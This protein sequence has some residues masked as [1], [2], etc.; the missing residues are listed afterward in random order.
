MPTAEEANP[1]TTWQAATALPVADCAGPHDGEAGTSSGVNIRPGSDDDGW[2]VPE[3]VELA[4]GS[5]VRLY[6][7]GE[8]LHAGLN[9]IRQ[10]KRRICLQSYIFADDETGHTFADLLCQRAQ[11]GVKVFVIFDSFGSLTPAVLW[12]EKPA[13]FDRMRRAGVRVHEFHPFRPWEGNSSWR[14]LNRD[15]RKVLICD[16]DVAGMGGLNVGQ[17]YAGSW[18]IKSKTKC[19][20]WRDNAIGVRGP[21]V[22]QLLHA[23][24]RAWNY[25]VHGGP[26]RRAEYRCNLREG[27]FGVLAS[28]P[29]IHSPLRP[30]FVDLLTNARTSID[31]T[32]AYFAPDDDLVGALLKAAKRGARVRLMLPSR[33]DV[34]ALIIA[35]R[36]FY[37]RLM[38]AG[39]EIYERQGVVLHAKTM[40][41]D[42]YTS[43]VGSANLDTR[44]I[45]FNL[46]LSAIIRNAEFG[47]QMRDLFDND[48]RYAHR[49]DPD[50]WRSRPYRDRMIQWMVSRARYL[51]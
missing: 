6:K 50:V 41:V 24:A 30:F 33:S 5:H 42:G 27:D 34:K 28:V 22:R 21:A 32:M 18:V 8:A 29:T 38:D 9:A 36:S 44:S 11:L 1:D 14:P 12:R 3:P 45:E 16:D 15:H 25:G 2:I 43:I 26:I 23:F 46:E 19:D 48:V 49:I 10:A 40:C 47:Q 7:D 37:E 4:D 35:A 39:I 20:P 17:E 31:M 51:L 13:M